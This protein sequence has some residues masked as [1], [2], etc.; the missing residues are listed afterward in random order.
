MAGE[1]ALRIPMGFPT[2]SK[3]GSFFEMSSLVVGMMMTWSTPCSAL[4]KETSVVAW[5]EN[6]TSLTTV[7]VNIN[8][9]I[10]SRLTIVSTFC[11][12]DGYLVSC[13]SAC[14][15]YE[16]K[17]AHLFPVSRQTDCVLFKCTCPSTWMTIRLVLIERVFYLNAGVRSALA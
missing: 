11:I 16:L 9:L 13:C 17:H 2:S 8:Y 15:K 5:M 10:T 3:L 6:G 12:A 14:V 7:S 4:P 1:T